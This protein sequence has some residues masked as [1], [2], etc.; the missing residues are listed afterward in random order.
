M[1]I[2]VYNL[3]RLLGGELVGSPDSGPGSQSPTNTR[4]CGDG[5][6]IPDSFSPQ[7]RLTGSPREPITR[8]P[9]GIFLTELHSDMRTKRKF[10]KTHLTRPR[11]GG[12]ARR[13]RQADH[14]K[15]LVALGVDQAAVDGMNQKEV[16]SMLKYPAKI[17][18]S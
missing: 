17:G 8:P 11:K 1:P 13:R 10:M 4:F 2:P 5:P 16:R 9:T 3:N 18:K 14:R 6:V 12:A 7:F 15:R